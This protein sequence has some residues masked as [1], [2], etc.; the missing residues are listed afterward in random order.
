MRVLDFS[1]HEREAGSFPLSRPE[2]TRHL[3][4]L[5]SADT[6]RRNFLIRCCQGASAGLLPARFRNFPLS[7]FGQGESASPVVPTAEFHLHL[8]P[9]YRSPTALDATLLKT[10]AGT[11]EF[12]SEKYAEQIAASYVAAGANRSAG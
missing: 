9:H 3:V 6:G 12:L 2:K 7:L 8:H 5:H 10:K 4:D 1:F 11:D